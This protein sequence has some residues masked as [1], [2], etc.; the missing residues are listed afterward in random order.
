MSEDDSSESDS[1]PGSL[2]DRPAFDGQLIT[3]SED[4]DS[5][6]RDE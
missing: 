2:A 5:S 3:N 4:K 1:E 6:S